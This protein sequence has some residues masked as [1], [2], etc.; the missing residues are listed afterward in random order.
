MADIEAVDNADPLQV[1]RLLLEQ[2]Q[3]LD[4]AVVCKLL[5]VSQNI[6]GLVHSLCAGEYAGCMRVC[7]HQRS[8]ASLCQLNRCCVKCVNSPQ[9]DSV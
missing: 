9:A 5:C 3:P 7:L 1:W 8:G 6:A 4:T 2:W